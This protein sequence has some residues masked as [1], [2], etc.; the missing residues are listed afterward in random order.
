MRYERDNVCTGYL[1]RQGDAVMKKTMAPQTVR[2]VLHGE[3][4]H[5]IMTRRRHAATMYSRMLL[6][7]LAG[8]FLTA[9]C[10][11]I[12]K[13]ASTSPAQERI[14]RIGGQLLNREDV[15]GVLPLLFTVSGFAAMQRGSEFVEPRDLLKAIY[16]VDLEHVSKFWDD[17]E[18]F[19]RLVIKGKLANAAEETY[20]NRTL[21]LVKVQALMEKNPG[22]AVEFGRASQS[23][24]EV[25]AAA[26]KSATNREGSIVTPSSMDLLYAICSHDTELEAALKAS[27]LATGK[28]AEAVSRR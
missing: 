28:L 2:R 14:A 7:L 23:L 12:A 24:L 5:R 8:S 11:E 27:G 9:E 22:T 18:G 6:I 3:R 25:V 1:V 26:R 17:W 20:L 19:E 4:V 16:V 10:Q 15:G 21:Y 13:Q